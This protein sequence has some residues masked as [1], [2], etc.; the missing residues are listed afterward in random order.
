[1]KIN[2]EFKIWP[3]WYSWRRILYY[4]NQFTL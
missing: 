4:I 3:W 1:M 2:L